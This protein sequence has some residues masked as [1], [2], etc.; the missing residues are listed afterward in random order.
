MGDIKMRKIIAFMM[1]RIFAHV[2]EQQLAYISFSSQAD[3]EAALRG[4]EVRV[5]AVEGS[6]Q[7]ST[8]ADFLAANLGVTVSSAQAAALAA[9][10]AHVPNNSF[11]IVG[12][13]GDSIQ[14][15]KLPMDPEHL[16]GD[17]AELM[18]SYRDRIRV[19][20]RGMAW[21]GASDCMT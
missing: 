9:A 11:V 3:I 10:V 14:I 16:F 21:H 15:E 18:R 12:F 19:S 17:G 20:L 5:R 13:C 7:G 1:T 8:P 2:S 6:I 4:A